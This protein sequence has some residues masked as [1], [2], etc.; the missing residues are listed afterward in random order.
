M[1]LSRESGEWQSGLVLFLIFYLNIV[2]LQCVSFYYTAVWISYMYIHTYICIYIYTHIYISTLFLEQFLKYI[3]SQ[4]IFMM[5]P[6][7]RI[8]HLRN[9]LEASG[10]TWLLP[11]YA[12]GGSGTAEEKF[13]RS[14]EFRA[15]GWG[16]YA[17]SD[18]H[19]N[20]N[21]KVVSGN[22]GFP[23]GSV[24]KESA[25]NAGDLG[26]IPGL[27]RSPGEGNGNPLQYSCF[28]NPTD[29]PGGLQ[30]MG[31]QTVRLD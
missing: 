19:L 27:G 20:P 8:Q 1:I 15:K 6:E 31:S 7:L 5:C 4:Q 10:L 25:C 29:E 23:G 24:G 2:V 22:T 12:D 16:K 17:F 26:F 11:S 3:F 18:M 9:S 21:D 13:S 14:W 30:F 28:E